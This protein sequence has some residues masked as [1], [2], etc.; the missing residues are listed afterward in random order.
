MN[1]SFGKLVTLPLVSKGNPVFGCLLVSLPQ[2]SGGP[3][4]QQPRR[5]AGSA[6]IHCQA[7]CRVG[8]PSSGLQGQSSVG[9]YLLVILP[10]SSGGDL[11]INPGGV[12]AFIPRQSAESVTP[13]P[14]LQGQFNVGVAC[15]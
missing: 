6:G 5:S 1:S 4:P 7:G 8:D 11:S 10:Q 9:G 3:K 13:S 15:W 2:G 14:G 12:Q